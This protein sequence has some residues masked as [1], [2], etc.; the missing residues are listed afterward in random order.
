MLIA[1]SERFRSEK[2]R[3]VNTIDLTFIFRF[4]IFQQASTLRD[5]NDI[6]QDTTNKQYLRMKS[7]IC[8]RAQHAM[9]LI[10]VF[11]EKAAA[12]LNHYIL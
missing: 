1:S 3:S 5:M 8:E 2:E 12:A 6:L 11:D 4:N 7:N 9:K 10:N